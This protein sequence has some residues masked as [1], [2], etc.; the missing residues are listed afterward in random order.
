MKTIFFNNPVGTEKIQFTVSN[1]SVKKLKADDI[2]PKESKTVSYPVITENSLKE[3]KYLTA[4]PDRCTFDNMENPTEVVIDIE[5]LNSF[6]L[7]E[8]KAARLECLEVLDKLQMRALLSNK[9]DIVSQIEKDKQMLRDL[10]EKINF[11]N[12]KTAEQGLNVI[13]V[14]DLQSEVYQYKYEA[15]LK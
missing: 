14:S 11:A 10:P 3:L 7:S 1:D 15:A 13:P 5:L 4:F 12:V 9:Q 8:T 6:W 2:I